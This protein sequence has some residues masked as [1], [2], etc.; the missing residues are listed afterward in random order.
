MSHKRRDFIKK[1]CL[2]GGC[3]CGFTSLVNGAVNLS[4]DMADVAPNQVLM[5]EWVSTLLKSI[6]E[7]EEQDVAQKIVKQCAISH[8]EHLKMDEFLKPYIG[9]LEKFNAFIE[10]KWGWKIDYQKEVGILIADENKNYCVCPMVNKEKGIKSSI[11]CYCSE[12]FAELMFSKVAD[13]QVQATVISSIH[14]G[15]DRCQYEIKLN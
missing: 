9:K 12:G 11:L 2:L 6:D 5:Q 4:D 3:L 13:M 7:N 10:N 1:S 15:Q 8:F 14:R